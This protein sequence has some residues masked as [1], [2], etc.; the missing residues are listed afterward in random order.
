MHIYIY[1]FQD[2]Y[3]YIYIYLQGSNGYTDIEYR[4]GDTEREAES[5]MS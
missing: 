4:F 5:G 1:I 3:I 2:L